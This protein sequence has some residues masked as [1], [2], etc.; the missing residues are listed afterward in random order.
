MHIGIERIKPGIMKQI[1]F[2][3]I[4]LIFVYNVFSQTPLNPPISKEEY[5]KRSRDLK[6]IGWVLVGAGTCVGAI[7]IT[8]ERGAV[9]DPGGWFS[10]ATYENDTTREILIVG[11]VAL[12]A[13][14]IPL[15]HMATKDKRKAATIGFNNQRL[16]FPQGNAFVSKTQTTMTLRIGL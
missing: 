9:K 11:G 3:L 1:S 15:F 13:G 8:L 7:G 4:L 16:L 5:L 2:S 10:P 12:I 6:T 14:C